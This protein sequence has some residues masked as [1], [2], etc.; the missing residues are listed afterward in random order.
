MVTLIQVGHI[1][2]QICGVVPDAALFSIFRLCTVQLWLCN[3]HNLYF[4]EIRT[5]FK[6]QAKDATKSNIRWRYEVYKGAI[7]HKK[8][9]DNGSRGG[10]GALLLGWTD[11]E[12]KGGECQI[13]MNTAFFLQFNKEQSTI[14]L[15]HECT[16]SSGWYFT[17]MP[18]IIQPWRSKTNWVTLD[19]A[20]G[21]IPSSFSPEPSLPKRRAE[22]SFGRGIGFCSR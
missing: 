18:A 9:R 22:I 1:K 16:I 8:K 6:L 19:A 10:E 7:S 21:A 12:R 5:V 14:V 3:E 11:E 2:C 20:Y 13:Y 4:C 17:I 15:R